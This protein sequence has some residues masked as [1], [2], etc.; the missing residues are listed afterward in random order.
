VSIVDVRARKFVGEIDT[1]G[2]ALVYPSGR[3]HFFRLR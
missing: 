2:C 3:A 1:A